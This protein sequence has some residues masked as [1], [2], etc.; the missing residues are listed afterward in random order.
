MNLHHVFCCLGGSGRLADSGRTLRAELQVRDY[1]MHVPCSALW[2][3][4]VQGS[5]VR[6]RCSELVLFLHPPSSYVLWVY[7]LEPFFVHACLSGSLL[8]VF[9]GHRS[10]ML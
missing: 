2:L 7:F 9:G 10:L 1:R 5:V 8:K 6:A 4:A 3:L